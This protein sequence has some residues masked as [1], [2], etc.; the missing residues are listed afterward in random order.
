MLEINNHNV[1]FPV[2]HAHEP[3]AC[4]VIAEE[5]REKRKKK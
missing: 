1:F 2:R 5:N 4:P 3:F